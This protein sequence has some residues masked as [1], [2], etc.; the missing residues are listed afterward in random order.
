MNERRSD[1]EER[2]FNGGITPLDLGCVKREGISELCDVLIGGPY[3]LISLF[4]LSSLAPHALVR[5]PACRP[6]VRASAIP[7]P[8]FMADE[9]FSFF[10]TLQP[11]T[12][13]AS[14]VRSFELSFLAAFSTVLLLCESRRRRRP[15]FGRKDTH[16]MEMGGRKEGRKEGRKGE[17]DLSLSLSGYSFLV[18]FPCSLMTRPRAP[19]RM[20]NK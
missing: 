6:P 12:T 16:S 18:G 8:I 15:Q 20:G 1:D 10:W 19:L 14:F 2:L 5:P 4:F 9:T 3:P 17:R 7:Q 11:T 13:V